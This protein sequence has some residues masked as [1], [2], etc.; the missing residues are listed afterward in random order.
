M[1]VCNPILAGLLFGPALLA[2][3]A[4]AQVVP[5]PSV[6]SPE[7]IAAADGPVI[8]QEEPADQRRQDRQLAK[9]MREEEEPEQREFSAQSD[10]PV[11]IAI[12][13]DGD[14]NFDTVETIDASA[15]SRALRYSNDRL[16]QTRGLPTV[17]LSGTIQAMTEVALF[18]FDQPHK[19]ARVANDEGRSAKVDLGPA[20]QLDELGLAEGDAIEVV[21]HR[22][23]IND[24][25]VLMAVEVTKDERSARLDRPTD[26]YMKRV[27]GELR[28]TRTS[29][30]RDRD[31]PF[32][33]AE[34]STAGGRETTVIL[35]PESVFKDVDLSEGASAAMLVR[36]ARLNGRKAMVAEQIRIGDRTISI[37][38]SVGRR[39]KLQS[40]PTSDPQQELDQQQQGEGE[41]S[42]TQSSSELDSNS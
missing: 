34:F 26:N 16:K 24:R 9:G 15:L 8:S 20:D 10:R 21:G 3:E 11:R 36:P 38:N 7:S 17:R 40:K 14:G 42:D 13:S 19:V 4:N 18:S 29:R 22:G 12:D 33:I 2:T 35:G 5:A 28:G 23:M 6:E 39:P 1:R 30:F 41:S 37:Q 27:R 31:E 25:P 32:V